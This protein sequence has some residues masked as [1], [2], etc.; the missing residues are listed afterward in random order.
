SRRGPR[1]P[2]RLRGRGGGVRRRRG[3]AH[4]RGVPRLPDRGGSGGVR[5]GV[6][7][8]ERGQRRHAHHRARRPGP[9]MVRRGGARA[10]GRPAGP[11]G[12]TETPGL[13]P[14]PLRGDAEDL[15]MLRDLTDTSRDVFTRACSARE[16]AEERRLAYVA[17][18]RAAYWVA[19][20][21]YWWGEAASPLGPSL[22][23]EEVRAACAGGAGTVAHWAPPPD[24][25]APEPALGDPPR[26][27]RAA[28]AATPRQGD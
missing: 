6:R 15:P 24:E 28:G 2:G 1:R 11:A 3:G 26:R 4:A 7:P 9:A 21:G 14:F 25:G 22:F 13:L 19:C 27:C 5:P 8:A 18:T 12:W 10:G 17:V 20:C 16:L 23:L